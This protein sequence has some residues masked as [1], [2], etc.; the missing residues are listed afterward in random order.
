MLNVVG[1]TLVLST[2]S[3]IVGPFFDKRSNIDESVASKGILSI[4]HALGLDWPGNVALEIEHLRTAKAIFLFQNIAKLNVGMSNL[5]CG[6]GI[7]VVIVLCEI[8]AATP[9]VP[10]FT[11]FCLF[12]RGRRSSAE[13][14]INDNLGFL[15]ACI[16]A[17]LNSSLKIDIVDRTTVHEHA[18]ILP[19]LRWESTWN[20]S[21]ANS[22]TWK[23]SPVGIRLIKLG[24]DTV[25]DFNRG[26]SYSLLE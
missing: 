10:S 5:G 18:L 15:I 8:T 23:V 12:S 16:F 9:I 13:K 11:S 3:F 4:L 22:C 21:G 17:L 24:I 1:R 7:R 25:I 14:S 6:N 19:D 2:K 26:D 20:R